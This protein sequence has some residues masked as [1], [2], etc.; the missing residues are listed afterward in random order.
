[1]ASMRPP[2]TPGR[3]LAGL[4]VSSV[5]TLAYII[6]PSL[7]LVSVVA[8]LF[9]WPSLPWAL[10]IASPVLISILLP[11]VPSPMI[12]RRLS[13]MLDY[14]DY[15]QIV[16]SK[17][18]DV[19]ANMRNGTG[20]Y[21][22]ATQPHGVVSLCGI[23]SAVTADKDFQGRLIPTGVAEAVLS[24]PILKQVMGIFSLISASKDSL[25]RN[26]KKGGVEGSVV[27]YVGGIAELFVSSAKEETLY[28]SKR[29]GF[30]KLAL[31]SGVDVVPIYLFGNTTCLTVLKTEMLAALSRKTQVSLTYFWGRFMLPI[32]RP[33][34]VSRTIEPT[35]A[36]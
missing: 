13:P 29:R 30:I 34:K 32:P 20:T 25:V 27:L 31:Q 11:P 7:I 16:E 6:A 19:R 2:P 1:M 36:Q 35:W 5:F 21:I 8:V 22:F 15:E 4:A 17:P 26:F 18:V 14:F 3:R 9:Q 12:I 23:C 24:T 28:L 10:V 33:V